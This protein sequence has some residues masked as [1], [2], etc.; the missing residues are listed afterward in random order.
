MLGQEE[1]LLVD[2]LDFAVPGSIGQQYANGACRYS[3]K[4]K[5]EHW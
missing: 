3:S 4:K 2:L 1:V 5:E